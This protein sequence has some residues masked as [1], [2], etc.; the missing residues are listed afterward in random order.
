MFNERK[1]PKIRKKTSIKYKKPIDSILNRRVKDI[2]IQ[3]WVDKQTKFLENIK[4]FK[5][6]NQNNL[7]N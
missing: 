5:F 6:T 2:K 4:E 7:I 3:F 1:H